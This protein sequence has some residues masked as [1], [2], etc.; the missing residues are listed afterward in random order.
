[1]LASLCLYHNGTGSQPLAEVVH[2]QSG[3]N[4]LQDRVS[5]AGMEINHTDGIFQIPERGLDAPAHIIEFLN[6]LC[7][8]SEPVQGRGDG[9][10][11]VFRYPEPHDADGHLVRRLEIPCL[12]NLVLAEFRFPV[13][14]LGGSILIGHFVLV[15][16]RGSEFEGCIYIKIL[17][18]EAADLFNPAAFFHSN[19]VV[20]PVLAVAVFHEVHGRIAPVADED[21]LLGKIK[22]VYHI[23]SGL[24]LV[25]A[26]YALDDGI[27]IRLVHEVVKCADM[28]LVEAV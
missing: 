10:I 5:L 2:H 24:R 18:R 20:Q 15:G 9:L 25:D 4:L 26:V 14:K 11:P 17:H 23:D 27:C 21:A 12:R 16:L 19:Q 28:I 1:M 22:A 6:A 7:R 13:Y 8:E 3:I